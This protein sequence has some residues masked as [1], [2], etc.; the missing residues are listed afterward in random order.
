M[1]KNGPRAQQAAAQTENQVERGGSSFRAFTRWVSTA[2][3]KPTAFV[4]SVAVV[5]LWAISGPVFHFSD[6]WQLAINTGTTVVTFWMVFVIQA[7]QNADTHALQLKLDELIRS[8]DSAR[9]VFL[10]CEG[11]PDEAVAK[12][13]AEFDELRR[14]AAS[15][16]RA[17]VAGSTEGA[18]LP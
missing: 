9:N 8:T 10:G 17:P 16:G 18:T 11:L 4:I 13:Q 15:R 3:G 2:S 6:T 5:V 14:R 12:F 7:S 1:D